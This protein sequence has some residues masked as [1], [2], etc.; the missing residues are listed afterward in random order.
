MRN[1]G[2]STEGGLLIAERI[3]APGVQRAF[4]KQGGTEGAPPVD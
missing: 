4:R 2:A 3:G 1:A